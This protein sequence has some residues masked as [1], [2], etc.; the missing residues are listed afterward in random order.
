MGNIDLDGNG[1]FHAFVK[2]GL[3]SLVDADVRH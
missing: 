3:L 2:R 1:R